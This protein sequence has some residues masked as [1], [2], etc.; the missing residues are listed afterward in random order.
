ME[1]YNYE[2]YYYYDENYS[3]A[4]NETDFPVEDGYNK[5]A[6]G[7][8]VYVPP[9]LIVLGCFG[10]AMSFIVLQS[11]LFRLTP[12]G[13][14]LS[15]LAVVDSGV[16]LTGLLRLWIIAMT[17]VDFRTSSDASCKALV[18]LTYAFPQI[19]SWTLVLVTADRTVSVASP[20]RSKEICTFFRMVCAWLIVVAIAT[21]ACVYPT[22]E[23]TVLT[24]EFPGGFTHRRCGVIEDDDRLSTFLSVYSWIDLLFV[25]LIPMLIILSCNIYIVVM[26]QEAD[27]RRQN[28]SMRGRNRQSSVSQS[29]RNMRSINIMLVFIGIAFLVTTTPRSIYLLTTTIAMDEAHQNTWKIS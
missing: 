20:I 6:R 27:Q 5:I 29:T 9:F 7:L 15:A 12:C 23:H 22:V 14:L 28:L 26:L 19:S 4:L 2:E 1:E 16:L 3:Y 11:P 18:F 24:M 21:L 10:N 25:A 17:G 8:M 13:Y